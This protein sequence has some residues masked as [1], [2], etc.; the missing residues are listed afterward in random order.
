MIRNCESGNLFLHDCPK[1]SCDLSL[2]L[3][4]HSAADDLEDDVRVHPFALDVV[5]EADD[6]SF[7][8]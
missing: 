1:V 6:G 7:G 4:V 5:R 2:V 3:V 8:D